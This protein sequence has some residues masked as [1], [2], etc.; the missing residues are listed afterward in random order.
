MTEITTRLSEIDREHL[1]HLYGF[2]EP[3]VMIEVFGSVAR[4]EQTPRSDLDVIMVVNE[5]E[6]KWWMRMVTEYLGHFGRAFS[7]ADF[8]VAAK[9]ARLQA[10]AIVF[11]TY[12]DVFSASSES[13][14]PDVFLFPANW[15]D[16]LDTLQKMGRHSDPNFMANVAR[17]ALRYD[18]ETELLL[19]PVY[20]VG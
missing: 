10:A 2:G 11:A 6:F 5:T 14:T 20:T 4:G 17:D 8:Y 18:P 1:D 19:G 7:N 12:P 15:R 9:Y 16:R 13:R 3:L